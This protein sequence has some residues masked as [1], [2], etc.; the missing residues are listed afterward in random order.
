M[1][2]PLQSSE[3]ARRPVRSV[4]VQPLQTFLHT[5]IASGVILLAAAVAALIWANSSAYT[6]YDALWETP[7]SLRIGPFEIAED[8]RHWV[9]DLLMAL[10]FF[11]VGLEIKREL[12]LGDLR[13]PRAAALPLIGALGGM[14]APALLYLVFN[15][16]GPGSNGWG[17]PMA[18]DIAFAVGVLALVGSR[19]PS[20]LKVFLLTLAVA[21]DLGAILVIAL[22]Y[23]RG[24][25][26]SW[27]LVALLAVG[28][29]LLLQRFGYRRYGP[30]LVAAIVLW[31]AVF[32]SGVHATIAG[33]V[34]GFLTPS[35]PLHPPEAVSGL[36]ERHLERLQQNPPDGVADESEQATL[37][38][39]A[40]LAQEGVSPLA[41]LQAALHPWT[42]FVVLPLFALAN[43][44]V[45]LVG[46]DVGAVLTD[47]VTI[48][49]IAGLVVG[50][51]LGIVL[52][53]F[54]AVKAGL[55]SLPHAVG[56][57][58][59][60][61]VGL[62][63]GVGFTVAIFIAGLAFDDPAVTD[64]AKLGIL[65]ASTAAGVLGAAFLAA[66]NAGDHKDEVKV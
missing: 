24:L 66:R 17:V 57:L 9:N 30:Y 33:V 34:L 26:G 39:V 63:A 58:E 7:L 52:A 37:L 51:P 64:A 28:A 13:D 10:F 54:I 32:E 19:A 2:D 41:R 20:S 3:D 35:R 55:G 47:S 62:L 27:L 8:L 14:I 36:A 23:T 21:D 11:V 29:I 6:S 53:T 65:V 5:E 12:V 31:L 25:A 56:W 15:A 43:A 46:T 50:K 49:I 61:G 18:T 38:E 40:R 44:G 45:R 59:M 60:I 16:D 4:I 1:T 42:S 48:G 22:F